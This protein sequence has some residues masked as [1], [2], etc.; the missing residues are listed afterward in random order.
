M[1]RCVVCAKYILRKGQS[2]QCDDCCKHQH[3]QCID[4][5]RGGRKTRPSPGESKECCPCLKRNRLFEKKRKNP[6]RSP[7]EIK[8]YQERKE[9]EEKLYKP[10]P[11]CTKEGKNEALDKNEKD[12][13]Y[14]SNTSE[15][16]D[17]CPCCSKEF[18]ATEVVYKYVNPKHIETNIGIH[19]FTMYC[20]GCRQISYFENLDM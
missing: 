8:L 20:N 11:L 6:F 17:C 2:F 1:D 3:W 16:R 14:V 5:S 9:K 15:P 7:R 18:E 4:Y 10:G 13:Y 12:P 19:T